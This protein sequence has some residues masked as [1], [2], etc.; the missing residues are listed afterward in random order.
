MYRNSHINGPAPIFLTVLL[1]A[2]AYSSGLRAQDEEVPS[3]SYDPQT[4]KVPGES[5]GAVYSMS[6][7]EAVELTLKNSRELDLRNT[8][9]QIER[10][11]L[12]SSGGVNNPELRISRMSTRYFTDEFDELE[13]GLRWRPPR[14]GELDEDKNDQ[15]VIMCEIKVDAERYRSELAMLALRTYADV[16]VYDQMVEVA[17]NRLTLEKKRL[18]EVEQIKEI[19]RRSI[20]YYTKASLRHETS[21][22]DYARAVQRRNT[23]RRELARL[24]GIEQAIAVEKLDPPDIKLSLDDLLRIA[25]KNRP[26]MKLIAPKLELARSRYD[27]ERF[28]LI[29][30][31]SYF[32]L[33]YH[34][35]ERDI[36]WGEFMVGIELP[37]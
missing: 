26:E 1:L 27:A 15:N 12:R 5:E 11:K 30:W 25:E 19:G 20:V 18:S 31:F 28:K 37:L 13:L 16:V 17:A 35:E 14:I 23:A 6:Q 4:V 29:P 7:R 34:K 10:N 8:K 36:D 2:F 21:K 33:S 9:A 24:T 22:S 3:P 32:E